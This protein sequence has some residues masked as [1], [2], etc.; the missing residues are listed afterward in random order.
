MKIKR[1]EF[2]HKITNPYIDNVDLFVENEDGQTYTIVV[3]TPD[4]LLEEMEQDKMNFIMPDT[5]KNYREKIDR[6]NCYRSNT[7]LR[8]KLCVLVETLSVWR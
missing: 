1:I 3:S 4:N 8:G 7:S 2:A 6:A 5:P